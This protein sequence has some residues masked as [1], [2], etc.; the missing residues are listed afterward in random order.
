MAAATVK[1]FADVS[2][3]RQGLKKAEGDTDSFAAK[4]EKGM[5]AV[6]AA[7]TA[8]V[9]NGYRLETTLDANLRIIQNILDLTVAQ[10]KELDDIIDK[11]S[12]SSG[13]DA[14]TVQTA[15]RNILTYGYSVK[16]TARIVDDAGNISNAFGGSIDTVANALAKTANQ[17]GITTDEVKY[18]GLA[19]ARVANTDLPGLLERSAQVNVA[20][21][22]MGLQFKDTVAVLGGVSR[23]MRNTRQSVSSL[24][25]LFQ[26]LGDMDGTFNQRLEGYYGG[27][28]GELVARFGSFEQVWERLLTDFGADQLVNQFQSETSKL[29]ARAVIAEQNTIRDVAG[30]DIDAAARQYDGAV[31]SSTTSMQ[32][33]VNTLRQSWADFQRDLADVEAGSPVHQ[34]VTS[35]TDIINDDDFR[36]TFQDLSQALTASVLPMS[37]LAKA[38]AKLGGANVAGVSV[39][40]LGAL[41]LGGVLIKRGLMPLGA[42]VRGGAALGKRAVGFARDPLGI[43]RGVA[44]IGT[45]PAGALPQ[46]TK[47]GLAGKAAARFGGASAAKLGVGAGARA[48]GSA[49]PGL[50]PLLWADFGLQMFTGKSLIFDGL[51]GGLFNDLDATS[52]TRG[53]RPSGRTSDRGLELGDLKDS[54][55]AMMAEASVR[56]AVAAGG[57]SQSQRLARARNNQAEALERHSEVIEEATRQWRADLYAERVKK[58]AQVVEHQRIEMELLTPEIGYMKTKA[59][60]WAHTVELGAER[61]DRSTFGLVVAGEI[62]ARK[63]SVTDQIKSDAVRISADIGE[64]MSRTRNDRGGGL[65]ASADYVGRHLAASQSRLREIYADQDITLDERTAYTAEL[66]KLNAQVTQLVG[67]ADGIQAATEATQDAVESVD[68]KTLEPEILSRN[69]L[70][71]S[72]LD[73]RGAP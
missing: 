68:D 64:Y 39:A 61:F 28:F 31:K 19:A 33:A 35:L 47:A 73:R 59:K 62:H 42:S 40:D 16:E 58:W 54:Y 4:A 37:V 60:N 27:N 18:Y 11:T 67:K 29:A 70:V 57:P 63:M 9:A 66:E 52:T 49:I 24:L 30:T 50:G 32:E 2:Q 14:A 26:E 10:R 21:A 71:Y 34:L 46:A 25:M 20:A 7:F 72:Q 56:A 48:A 53:T 55:D 12:I 43:G 3:Y 6:A 8:I 15:T 36:S 5:L 23:Q 17:Y 51:F 13:A 45:N 41:A 44:S 65:A 38:L 22:G 69:Y 1:F